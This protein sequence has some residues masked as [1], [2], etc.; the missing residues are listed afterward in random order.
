ML[1][2]DWRKGESFGGQECPCSSL[3][4][5]RENT[6]WEQ[7]MPQ[8]DLNETKSFFHVIKGQNSR[9]VND[10]LPQFKNCLSFDSQR[11]LWILC[12][13]AGFQHAKYIPSSNLFRMEI[14]VGIELLSYINFSV[15]SSK[16]RVTGTSSELPLF[17]M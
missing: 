12:I 15:F 7:L 17:F 6:F 4:I 16:N 11:C 10:S 13:L 9:T 1:Y 14:K 8:L 5:I 2:T 3:H